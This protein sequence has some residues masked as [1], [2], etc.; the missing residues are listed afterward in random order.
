M[1]T[2]LIKEIAVFGAGI[3]SS[4]NAHPLWVEI[5]QQHPGSSSFVKLPRSLV[6]SLAT[7]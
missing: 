5:Q 4:F 7:V 1:V 3:P 6:N 2:R